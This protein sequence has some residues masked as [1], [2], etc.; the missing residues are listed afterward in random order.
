MKNVPSTRTGTS[1]EQLRLDGGD[2][3]AARRGP[4]RR[5]QQQQQLQ[6][7]EST[8]TTKGTIVQFAF[9]KRTN[10]FEGARAAAIAVER[11][12]EWQQAGA[13]P[14]GSDAVVFD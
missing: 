1:G 3:E 10:H 4:G 5:Q 7:R 2:V 6:Q 12:V 9:I 8:A 14:T 13:D 11:N